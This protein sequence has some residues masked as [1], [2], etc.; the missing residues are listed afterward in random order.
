M[1]EKYIVP[2]ISIHALLAESDLFVVLFLRGDCVFLSTLSL[3]RA[4]SIMESYGSHILLF[5]STL[6]LRRATAPEMPTQEEIEISIHALLAESDLNNIGGQQSSQE[7]LSTLSLRRAT[8]KDC[9]GSSSSWN[10]YPRSPCGERPNHAIFCL[11][12]KSA[13]LSTLS[14]R[15][16]T[17][18]CSGGWGRSPNF[19][20]RSP[21]GERPCPP[22]R[23]FHCHDFYPR[24]PCGERRGAISGAVCLRNF[25]PRSPCGERPHFESTD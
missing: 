10:F 24:S 2:G 21:C 22:A 3:R 9:L 11:C 18:G 25:Y 4:T 17:A 13:F 6:S 23:P 14:L 15:R 5:L 7:F 20:P 8:N 19:Y 16:A 1:L 12:R